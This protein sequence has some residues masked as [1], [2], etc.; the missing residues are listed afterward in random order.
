MNATLHRTKLSSTMLGTLA[1]IASSGGEAHPERGGWWRTAPAPAGQRLV[2]PHARFPTEM[3]SVGT[4]TIMSLAARELLEPI[5]GHG[6]HL[7]S[8][9]RLTQTARDILD[10]QRPHD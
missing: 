1:A 10:G 4:T 6:G 8:A 5:P 3:T 9:Y 2:V 7:H